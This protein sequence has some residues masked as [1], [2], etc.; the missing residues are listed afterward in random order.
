MNLTAPVKV[1]P[2]MVA[3]IESLIANVTLLLEPLS[4]RSRPVPAVRALSLEREES[5]P[6]VTNAE[7]EGATLG[8]DIVT[9]PEDPVAIDIFDPAMRYDVPLLN[10]VRDPDRF[11]A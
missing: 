1:E 11:V 9:A 2:L 10:L 6:I 4:K 3:T 5:F 7:V 8:A